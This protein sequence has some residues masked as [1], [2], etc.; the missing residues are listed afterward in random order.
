MIK[1]L[2]K[3]IPICITS[4][5]WASSSLGQT[6]P[7]A[8]ATPGIRSI[9]R[10]W[11]SGDACPATVP[12]DINVQ[13]F[14][15]LPDGPRQFGVDVAKPM[16]TAADFLCKCGSGKT[17]TYPS[18]VYHVVQPFD[19]AAIN[20]QH[21]D[22]T[23]DPSDTVGIAYVGCNNVS[24]RGA[25]STAF[26]PGTVIDVN[27][28]YKK[29]PLVSNGGSLLVPLTTP[30]PLPQ[31]TQEVFASL[32]AKTPFWI[33]DSSRVSISGL[34]INGH[35]NDTT[36]S[37]PKCFYVEGTEYGVM[38]ARTSDFSI[39]NMTILNMN[40]DGISIDSRG[41][42]IDNVVVSN[43]NRDALSLTLARDIRVTHS[44]FKD[45]G[46]VGTQPDSY[47]LHGGTRGVAFEPEAIPNG[48][49]WKVYA[50]PGFIACEKDGTP[51]P[52]V[53]WP[54]TTTDCWPACEHPDDGLPTPFTPLTF[55]PGNF[56]FDNVTVSGNLG[57]QM[58]FSQRGQ[59]A[60]VTVINSTLDNTGAKPTAGVLEGA[61]AGLY[62]A[63]SVI[64]AAQGLIVPG[65]FSGAGLP[66]VLHSSP[67]FAAHLADMAADPSP[68][69]TGVFRE[70]TWFESTRLLNNTIYGAANI[71]S[72]GNNL[73]LFYFWNNTVTGQQTD[74]TVPGTAYET[75]FYLAVRMGPAFAN[76]G[77][78]LPQAFPSDVQ[79]VNNTF[80]IPTTA[81]RAA[82][83][84]AGGDIFF[85]G[86]TLLQN[87]HYSAGTFCTSISCPSGGTTGTNLCPPQPSCSF[88]PFRVVYDH[89]PLVINDIFPI[90]GSPEAPIIPMHGPLRDGDP[91]DYPASLPY[92]LSTTGAL[93]IP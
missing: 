83:D 40:T 54:T 46:K 73:P 44:T 77:G 34:T 33:Q 21:L 37:D 23:A 25:P 7:A 56:F 51:C 59:G 47:P 87:N 30:C 2:W 74:F 9:L 79:F 22:P 10:N 24:I 52:P 62:V 42:T 43:S 29:A 65:G 55:L 50:T 53:T 3:I 57:G 69:A 27:G 36:V 71:L 61:V 85:N 18:G 70:T 86:V 88:E 17:L 93:N 14:G 32:K 90:P 6:L 19:V 49:D 72:Q 64:N 28:N 78:L 60:N 82:P 38:M 92:P 75:S 11:H 68:Y 20:N 5:V 1:Y 13:F 66:N 45:T 8:P 15:V 48:A 63:N 91:P 81:P 16:Q 31:G 80:F 41:G 4:L 35:G 58:S 89:V 84:N 26:S 67:A 76:G 39:A 12:N